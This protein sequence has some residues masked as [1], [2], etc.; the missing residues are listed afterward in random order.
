M[1]FFFSLLIQ[2]NP[3][4]IYL[5]SVFSLWFLCCTSENDKPYLR[6]AA[7]KSVLRLATRWDSHISPELF[8]TALLMARVLSICYTANK[9]LIFIFNVGANISAH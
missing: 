5:C 2:V 4:F 6:L 9:H 1:C 3:E 8:R 7:G